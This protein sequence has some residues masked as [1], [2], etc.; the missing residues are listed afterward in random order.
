MF[1]QWLLV[2]LAGATFLLV[3]GIVIIQFLQMNQPSYPIREVAK[4]E[5]TEFY[6]GNED[7]ASLERKKEVATEQIETKKSNDR[8]QRLV[9][10]DL[11]QVDFSDVSSS[12][13]VSIDDILNR[14][15]LN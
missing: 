9:I 8:E 3:W 15:E 6:K 7:L 1:K 2:S 4:V 13:G 12:E 14:L 11:R 5:R 10:K